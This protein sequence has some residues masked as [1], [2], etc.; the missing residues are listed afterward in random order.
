MCD[1]QGAESEA[2]LDGR[3]GDAGALRLETD[4]Q[5]ERQTV[6]HGPMELV[7]TLMLGKWAVP[8]GERN[9]LIGR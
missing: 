4:R 7:V 6:S 9:S 1:C 3:D 5:T 2:G 8:H